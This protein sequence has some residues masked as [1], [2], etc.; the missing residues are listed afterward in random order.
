MARGDTPHTKRAI[1]EPNPPGV[2]PSVPHQLT[3]HVAALMAATHKL[4]PPHLC[5]TPRPTSCRCLP[6]LL[7]GHTA[8][9]PSANLPGK[10]GLHHS[11]LPLLH[12]RVMASHSGRFA[13]P[14][15]GPGLV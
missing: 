2:R 7:A 1:P 13:A 3:R 10:P 15:A 5:V 4:V 8:P 12:G 11:H 9:T 6:C 14:P